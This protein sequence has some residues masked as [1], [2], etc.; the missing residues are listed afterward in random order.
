MEVKAIP[1]ITIDGLI[2]SMSKRNQYLKKILLSRFWDENF[3]FKIDLQS[4]ETK[5][6]VSY[7]NRGK[8]RIFINGNQLNRRHSF[9]SNKAIENLL[10]NIQNV[11]IRFSQQSLEKNHLH[12]QVFEDQEIKFSINKVPETEIRIRA[13]LSS[14]IVYNKNQKKINFESDKYDPVETVQL[15]EVEVVQNIIEDGVVYSPRQVDGEITFEKNNRLT[16]LAKQSERYK[17]QG[18]NEWGININAKTWYQALRAHIGAKAVMISSDGL[19][20]FFPITTLNNGQLGPLWV[21]DGIYMDR[22]PAVSSLVRTIREVKILKYSGSSLYGARG[23]EG[24]IL[25]KTANDLNYVVSNMS[26]KLPVK[27]EKNRDILYAYESFEKDFNLRINSLEKKIEKY[28]N[29]DDF[30]EADSISKLKEEI[31]VRGY[32][33]T[34]NYI[35]KNVNYEIA[36]YLA[37]TKISDIKI[38]FLDTIASNLPK[39][40]KASKYGKMFIDFIRSRKEKE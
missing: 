8:V 38:S 26:R 1:K 21:I 10:L 28:L 29:E 39:K 13:F 37:L 20:L 33:F 2:Y 23:S 7:K 36:P 25:I 40:V 18:L 19:P 31:L 24:V 4:F 15:E 34:A 9:K 35:N 22:P 27:G 5:K 30:I 17:R 6:K 16:R 11:E 32:L 12:S 14:K 3:V